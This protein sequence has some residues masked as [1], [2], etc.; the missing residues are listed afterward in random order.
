MPVKASLLALLVVAIWGANVVAI[1]A[2]VLEMAPLTF[3]SLRFSLTALAF[4]PFIRW[5]GKKMALTI[6]QVGV[7]M[8]VLHHGLLYAGL[9][10]IDAGT[11][12]IIL[13]MQVVFTALL[14]W[15]FLSE[16]IGWRTWTGIA[17]GIAGIAVLLGG[18]TLEGEVMGFVYGLVST[19]F[20]AL[21]YIRMKALRGVH[22]LT[23][24]A[25][26]N[27]SSALPML[28]ISY[29]VNPQ[30]WHIMADYDWTLLGGILAIQ[31]TVLAGTHIIWQ[32]LL[33]DNPVSMV[34]PWTLLMPVF[35]IGFGAVLLG[36]SIT[37]PMIIGGLL[38]IAGVGIITLRRIQKGVEPAAE[39]L[40]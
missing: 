21:C 14:G 17:L 6:M 2:G 15:L 4:L 38:T 13:Q 5:P 30:S 34:A 29:G 16:T 7:L 20:I 11:M 28:L 35:G 3:L 32:K 22:P 36:E 1:R 9:P 26:M 19:F 31:V 24:I 23:F 10:L 37:W 39:Q 8:G 18:P 25:G 33:A 12:S 40:D 27:L